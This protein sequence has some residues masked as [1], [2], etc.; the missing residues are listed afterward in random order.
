[1]TAWRP[2]AAWAMRDQLR[3][4]GT[5]LLTAVALFGLVVAAG[6][7]M[8][9]AR[10]MAATAARVLEAGPDLVVRRVGAAGWMPLPA[11]QAV[12]AVARVP[13]V[14]RVQT[15]IWGV[16]RCA[17]RPVTVMGVREDK[18]RPYSGLFVSPRTGEAVAGSVA[19]QCASGGTLR[20][21]GA[22]SLSLRL[23]ATLDASADGVAADLVL[24]HPQDA[25][26]LLGLPAGSVSDLALAVFHE[27]E[28]QALIPDIIEAFPWPSSV[29][30]RQ[31][32]VERYAAGFAHR[33]GIVSLM[34]VPALLALSLLVAGAAR[35]SQK[36]ESEAALLKAMGWT[37][38]DIVVVQVA[39]GGVAALVATGAGALL[40][41]LLVLTPGIHW[42][43]ELFFAWPGGTPALYLDASG[44]V[45]TLLQV[46]CF[47]LIPYTGALLWPVLRTAKTPAG[48][49]AGGD[50][51][52]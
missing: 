24:L 48:R 41:C 13:G 35:P 18:G 20:L 12:S 30:T 6:V 7:P 22:R 23:A 43:A 26:S 46:L 21:T 15:R 8:L 38:G 44:A 1:L 9:L 16:V 49:M 3:R 32:T 5:L 29:I 45:W 14:I 19:A 47:V 36:W 40:S 17:D 31:Q 10:A 37:T 2:L 50:W 34:L 51:T 52:L 42:P 28:A 33:A 4:P 25:R 39:G 27:G 11:S